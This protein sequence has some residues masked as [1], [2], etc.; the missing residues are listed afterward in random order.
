MNLERLVHDERLNAAIA[1]VLTA[2]VSASALESAFTGDLLWGGFELVV[3]A[4]VTAPA[5]SFRDWTAMV[6]WPLLGVATVA[7]GA[8][9]AGFPFETTVYLAIGA[10]AL[11]VVVELE[12]F[13]SVELSRRF[14]VGFAAMTTMALQA[15]WTVAQFYADRWLGTEYLRSQTELQWDF[16]VV[17]AV[18]LVL[19]AVFQW[20]TDRFDPVGAV[21]RA[22][23]GA[24]SP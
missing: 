1:W 9:A 15:L 13:T 21:T 24:D 22:A 4:V 16:V 2:I 7:F 23:N 14:A 5:I 20:Y 17:T 11:I 19:A 8:G 10:L 12:A 6:S 18:A 3:V